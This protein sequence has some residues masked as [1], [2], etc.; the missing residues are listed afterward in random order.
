MFLG[1]GEGGGWGVEGERK[2]G[3]GIG[4]GGS[5][6]TELGGGSCPGEGERAAED[7]AQERFSSGSGI[8][9]LP[10]SQPSP[11]SLASLVGRHSIHSRLELFMAARR[12]PLSAGPRR[13]CVVVSVGC[14]SDRRRDFP[15]GA[16]G[17]VLGMEHDSDLWL[18]TAGQQNTEV[19]VS[20]E[21][22]WQP[23]RFQAILSSRL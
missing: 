4:A 14:R 19:G 17:Q 11:V 7:G 13:E 20:R 9:D 12:Q 1:A 6:K 8:G 5:C 2:E 18:L 23:A 16:V 10:L 15:Q 22:R 3:N 21:A